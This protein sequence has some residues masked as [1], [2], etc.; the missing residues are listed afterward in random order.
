MR[1]ALLLL[2]AACSTGPAEHAPLTLA[3]APVQDTVPAELLALQE[4]PLAWRSGSVSEFERTLETWQ[5][6]PPGT[7]LSASGLADLRAGLSEGGQLAV[8][9]AVLLARS[10]DA[11]AT[12]VLI[13]RLEERVPAP[14]R[15]DDAADVVA[16]GALA[17]WPATPDDQTKRGT[18]PPAEDRG[19]GARLALLAAGEKP[20]PDLEVRVECARSALSRGRTDVVPF[21]LRVLR[22]ETPTQHL[23]PPDWER[24]ETVT[25]AKTRAAE[26]LALHLGVR[27]ELRPDGSFAHIEA[28]VHRYEKLLGVAAPD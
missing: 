22:A 12:Q 3:Q 11:R 19:I 4:P 1:P 10:G 13:E 16:A 26:A 28:E 18:E 7:E 24:V 27:Q 8:R 6:C 5:A 17:G 2:C 15:T 23:D 14:R 21:L 9:A 20:H 25:W